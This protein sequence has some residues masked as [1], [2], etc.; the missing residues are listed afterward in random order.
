MAV[1]E[2]PIHGRL[3]PKRFDEEIEHHGIAARWHRSRT[4]PCIDPRT[5]QAEIGCPVCLDEGVL[6]DEGTALKV[7]MPG[8]SRK[9]EYADVG[10][11][12]NGFVSITFPSKVV[13]GHYDKVELSESLM[14]A[15]QVLVRGATNK[16]GRS[17]E[18]LRY[19]EAAVAVEYCEAI[20]PGDPA[21]VL[22][23]STPDDFSLG[24]TGVVEWVPGHGP[25]SGKQYT[26]RY[27][28]RPTY[29]VWSPQ[30]REEGGQKL[31]YRVQA[32]RLEFFQPAVVGGA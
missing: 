2:L 13:P 16:L 5:G 6:W 15:R 28:A 14:I 20:D 9:D 31:P 7:L 1:S 8:R 21:A 19:R 4:C 3:D 29:I 32:Q 24:P 27:Q 26:V 10:H 12:M 18:R 22:S 17:R 23:F 25:A 30:E 11:W